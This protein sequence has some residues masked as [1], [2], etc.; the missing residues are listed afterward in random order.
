[1][2]KVLLIEKRHLVILYTRYAKL[3][4]YIFIQKMPIEVHDF[5]KKT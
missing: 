5:Q 2:Y 3:D 4:L 1:M